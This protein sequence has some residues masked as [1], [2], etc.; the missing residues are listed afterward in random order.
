V[1]PIPDARLDTTRRVESVCVVPP[2]AGVLRL[3]IPGMVVCVIID[4][5]CVAGGVTVTR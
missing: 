2:G 3:F 4:R 5:C 1:L